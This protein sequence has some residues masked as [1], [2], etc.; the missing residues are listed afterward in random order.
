MGILAIDTHR[1]GL[2]WEMITDYH[3]ASGTATSFPVFFAGRC[4]AIAG[5]KKSVNSAAKPKGAEHGSTTRCLFFSM[6]GWW[7]QRFFIFHDIY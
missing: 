6:S 5:G 3:S 1:M 7:F 4:Q 2:L